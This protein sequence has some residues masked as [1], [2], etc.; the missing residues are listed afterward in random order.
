MDRC[1]YRGCSAGEVIVFDSFYS[2][3]DEV[4]LNLLK[5][6]FA[7]HIKVKLEQIGGRV[8]VLLA[9]ANCTALA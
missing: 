9:T 5:Q 3:V 4:T 7:V 8:C 2:S 1:P 6:L